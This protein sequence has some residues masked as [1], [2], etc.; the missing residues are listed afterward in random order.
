MLVLFKGRKP[1]PVGTIREWQGKKYKKEANG[2]KP[3]SEGRDS[4]TGEDKKKRGRPKGSKNTD[5][6]FKFDL[7]E[8]KESYISGLEK[9]FN[10]RKDKDAI[11]EK[12]KSTGFDSIPKFVEKLYDTKDYNTDPSFKNNLNVLRVNL[13]AESKSLYDKV[14][15]LGGW[16]KL[17]KDNI[18]EGRKYS[19]LIDTNSFISSVLI[20]QTQQMTRFTSKGADYINKALENIQEFTINPNNVSIRAENKNDPSIYLIGFPFSFNQA[21]ALSQFMTPAMR[22][23]YLIALKA[24]AG[25]NA[26]LFET[27]NGP[28][29]E[30]VNRFQELTGL[31]VKQGGESFIFGDDSLRKRGAVKKLKSKIVDS[32]MKQTFYKD[33]LGIFSVLDKTISMKGYNPPDGKKLNIQL[34]PVFEG[35][36]SGAA[37]TYNED[38]TTINISPEHKGAI[39]HEIG[40]YFWYRSNEMQKEFMKWVEDSGLKKKIEESTTDLR[41]DKQ[42]WNHFIDECFARVADKADSLLFSNRTFFEKNGFDIFKMKHA[43][44]G[45]QLYAY[46]LAERAKEKS[47][48][49]NSTNDAK[50]FASSGQKVPE[51]KGLFNTL[52]DANT[53]LNAVAQQIINKVPNLP[54]NENIANVAFQLSMVRKA[55]SM[56]E[57]TS[58]RMNWYK[59][60][61]GTDLISPYT[62]NVY[63]DNEYNTALSGGSNVYKTKANYYK[64]PTEIFARTFRNYVSKKATGKIEFDTSKYKEYSSRTDDEKQMFKQDRENYNNIYGWDFPEVDPDES[65]LDF[66]NNRLEKILKKYIGESTMKSMVHKLVILMKG[67]KSVPI[68][69]KVAVPGGKYYREKTATGWKHVKIERKG[70]V[71]EDD[72]KRSLKTDEN[73]KKFSDYTLLDKMK[74]VVRMNAEIDGKHSDTHE[75]P[76]RSTLWEALNDPKVKDIKDELIDY[77]KEVSKKA[78]EK[79]LKEEKE[80]NERTY[81][82]KDET[83]KKDSGWKKNDVGIEVND[84]KEHLAELKEKLKDVKRGDEI[85]VTSSNGKTYKGKF[86]S[87]DDENLRFMQDETGMQVVVNKFIKDIKTNKTVDTPDPK[88]DIKEIKEKTKSIDEPEKTKEKIVNGLQAGTEVE[89]KGMKKKAIIVTKHRDGTVTVKYGKNEK[90]KRIKISKIVGV[91][92]TKNDKKIAK[93]IESAT[94]ETRTTVDAQINGGDVTQTQEPEKYDYSPG[95]VTVNDNSGTTFEA[96]DFTKVDLSKIFLIPQ[97]K[98]LKTERPSYIPELSEKE[99]ASWGNRAISTKLKDGSYLLVTS[100]A[101]YNRDPTQASG[102]KYAKVPLEILCATQDYYSKKYKAGVADAKAVAEAKVRDEIASMRKIIADANALSPA[103]LQAKGSVFQSFLEQANRILRYVDSNPKYEKKY[104][105]SRM[106]KA[107]RILNTNKMTYVESNLH[108]QFADQAK[109]PGYAGRW[110][111]HNEIMQ[112]MKLKSVDMTIQFHDS[113]DVYGKGEETSYGDSGTKNT[114]LNSHGVKVKRQNG[115]EITSKEINEVKAALDDVYKVFGNKSELSKKFGLK[116]SHAGQVMMHA[117]KAIGIFF[118][119]FKAIGVSFIDADYGGKGLTLAHEFAHFMDYSSGKSVKRNFHSDDWNSTAGKISNKL[120][121]QLKDYSDYEGRTCECFA[122]SM[123]SFF[124]YKTKGEDAVKRLHTSRGT[125]MY[126]EDI[127]YMKKEIYPLCEQYLKENEAVL[128][129]MNLKL[130]IMD[131]SLKDKLKK[132]GK[133]KE[134]DKKTWTEEQEDMGTKVEMEH[135]DDPTIARQIAMDHL[136][137]DSNYYTKLKKMEGGK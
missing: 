34:T 53:D 27:K 81:G 41:E 2:W 122:R 57:E 78:R 110:K 37:G 44:R 117:R 46:L 18:E 129:S 115:N 6:Q 63:F 32:A 23:K 60:G 15:D 68:G 39:T 48:Y 90:T 132:E 95:K 124:A 111:I 84:S 114:L 104:I 100:G 64:E 87:I 61:D 30:L 25:Y 7:D 4:D 11:F 86:A 5:L 12:I 96:D 24:S 79:F 125:S 134:G 85:E 75:V 3:V 67:R 89:V 102:P 83:D 49:Y 98:V 66:D 51:E 59:T 119:R 36:N 97:N 109:Y 74:E 103:E 113:Y 121:E 77:Y 123:E 26:Y 22:R 19:N 20:F 101:K 58:T 112:D 130:V 28:E 88:K 52:L 108:N 107:S 94:P 35:F 80:F 91:S 70:K 29:Q 136:V 135:T 13:E 118:P 106:P 14:K 105:A 56:V 31:K 137:E 8:F 131:K 50:N 16:E 62:Y 126:P 65:M 71:Q 21:K 40:H 69:T 17:Y 33:V 116:I 99:F 127:E 120:R 47:K 73:K 45:M 1:L 76:K 10:S 54:P 42:R 93:A 43:V 92:G 38:D 55:M 133:Y 9:L 72:K 82:K 128:K